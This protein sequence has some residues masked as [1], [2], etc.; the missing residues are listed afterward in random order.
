MWKL[1][2][3]DFETKIII[4]IWENPSRFVNSGLP[5]LLPV[6]ITHG[7]VTIELTC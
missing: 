7:S 3:V 5:S 2:V 4:R 1:V 6:K